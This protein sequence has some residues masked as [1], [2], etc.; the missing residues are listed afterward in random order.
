MTNYIGTYGQN[1]DFKLRSDNGKNS[2][3]RRANEPVDDESPSWVKITSQ[4]SAENKI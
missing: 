3:E 4:K 1:L 2:C